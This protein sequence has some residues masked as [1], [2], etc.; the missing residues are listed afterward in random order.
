MILTSMTCSCEQPNCTALK[1]N[2]AHSYL[3]LPWYFYT[4]YPSE[5]N[6]IYNIINLFTP[7]SWM[8]TFISIG[9]IFLGLKLATWVGTRL[10]LQ[11]CTEEIILFPL[12]L[13]R[14]RI[15]VPFT[16]ADNTFF[17]RFTVLQ[18]PYCKKVF[19]RGFSYNFMFLTW[20]V[21][22]GLLR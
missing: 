10:G 19:P 11:T 15:C 12:R 16:F 21:F 17:C 1:W 8:W 6:K 2:C 13:V 9:S 22:G 14:I 20:C 18:I 7:T 5:T 4:K 3:F